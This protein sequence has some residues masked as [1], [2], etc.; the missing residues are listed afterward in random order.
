LF[1]M[2]VSDQS[3]R[4]CHVVPGILLSLC[5]STLAGQVNVLTANYGN[6][7]TNANEQEKVLTTS[8]VNQAGFGRLGKF[9]VDGRIYAQPLYVAG[10]N[11]QGAAARNVVYI[12]TMHNSV[13]AIDADAPTSTVPLWQMNFGMSVPCSFLQIDQSSPEVG[14]LSTPVIDISRNSIYLVTDT[15]ENGTAVLRLHALDLS[16]G[17]EKLGGPAIIKAIVNGDGDASQDGTINLDP[18]QHIQRAGL[19]LVNDTVYIAFASHG[20]EYPYHGWITAYDASN[21]QRQTAVFNVT[22]GGG[23]GGIWQSGRG[24]ASDA[25][26]NIYIATGNGDYDGVRNFSESFVKLSPNLTV[27]DWFT[28]K[29][30]SALSDG[31]YD[32]GS[33][34]PVLT[35]GRFF[36]GGDKAGNMYLVDQQNLGRLGADG[37]SYPKT[38][39]PIAFGGI[40]NIAVWESDRGLIVYVVEQGDSTKALR[41]MDGQLEIRPFSETGVNSDIPYQGMA[42]SANGRRPGTGIL[43]MTTGDHDIPGIPGTLHAFDAL[44][45]QH[46]LWHSDMNRDRDQLGAFA[47][48]VAPT[49]ANGRVYVPTSSNQLA[50]YGLVPGLSTRAGARSTIPINDD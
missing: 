45:L 18:V 46:E 27:L 8:N 34:G 2:E 38:F 42:I 44:D 16:D 19:L 23:G 3:S 33:L 49:V 5:A 20:D 35:P 7:R 40:F 43:W 21:I 13:Y 22:V 31:D 48:F 10:V 36:I 1:Q 50:I 4:R 17:H 32:L 30:W 6:G 25:D 29:N 9:P 26:G 14:I 39:Q 12:A 28:P 11:I 24:L 15:Y 47:K 37:L 41:L